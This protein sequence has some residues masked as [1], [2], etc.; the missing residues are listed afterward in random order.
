MEY[1]ERL[2]HDISFSGIKKIFG[3]P[4]SGPSLT[5]LDALS[6]QG[7][8]FYLTHFEGSAVLMAGVQGRLTGRSGVAV[9]IKG[10]GLANMVPGLAACSLEAFP[11]VSITEAYM[12]EIPFSKAHKRLDHKGLVS[13]VT[14]GRRFLS[15]EGPGFGELA[16][17]AEAEVPGPVHMDISGQP[18]SM[19]EPIPASKSQGIGIEKGWERVKKLVIGCERPVVIAGTLAVRKG[20]AGGELNRLNIPVFS[21]A[22][23]KGS[24]DERLSNAAGVYTG[25]GLELTPEKS[26]LSQADMVIGLGLRT[27]EVL[28]SSP[29]TCTAI[30]IDPA[31]ESCCPGFDFHETVSDKNDQISDFFT[32]LHNKSWG[33]DLV[34][35]SIEK[36]RDHLLA[37]PFMPA[38]AFY[39]L[40]RQF[41]HQARLVLDTGHF[42]TIGEH[43]WRAPSPDLCLGAGQG[44]YMGTGLPM[45]IGAALLDSR[46]PTIAVLGDGGI[47]MFVSEVKLAVAQKVPLLIV[48][49]TDGYLG[50]IRTRALKDGMD[51]GPV[52]IIRPSWMEVFESFDMPVGRAKNESDLVALME[53]WQP[54][55]GPMYMELAFDPD[56]YQLMGE[57][58]R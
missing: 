53:G 57:G 32:I 46:V 43:V 31:G 2:A 37:G 5:L 29:F 36:M 21:T 49:M 58:I 33:L 12:P 16:G 39:A 47:G 17:W 40:E 55:N 9:G 23:A 41:R 34:S 4:G 11:V 25:V 24:V 8:S 19:D 51:Q 14:K 45:A 1:L 10:P 22:A 13:A 44:R 48:L 52:T 30:N 35:G 27:N 28:S 38:Q 54:E 6:R 50:S 56:L 20:W 3:I 18:V 15:K 7:V 42:C 26:I